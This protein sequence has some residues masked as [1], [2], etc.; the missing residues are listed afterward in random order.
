M[1]D[2]GTQ[3]Y[4]AFNVLVGGLLLT[5]FARGTSYSAVY[6]EDQF[7]TVV[8]NRGHGAW[9][10]KV[11]LAATITIELL[12]TSSQNDIFSGIW[13]ANYFNR[14]R[15]FGVPLV[16]KDANGTTTQTAGLVRPTKMADITRSDSIDS[17]TWT[18]K[19]T[20]LTTFA[21]GN[22]APLI[23]TAAQAAALAQVLRPLPVAA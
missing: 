23:G 19:T 14:R 9:L 18:L 21:G 17:R 7:E 5:G 20:K 12:A 22:F 6:D 4:Q 3:D 8:G 16:V 2:N 13:I 11:N 10:R 15:G 1:S